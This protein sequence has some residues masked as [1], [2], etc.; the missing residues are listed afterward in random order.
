MM[1][2]FRESGYA[3][4]IAYGADEAIAFIQRYLDEQP[5]LDAQPDA[6]TT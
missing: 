6:E 3:A 1:E 2:L 4:V 5:L